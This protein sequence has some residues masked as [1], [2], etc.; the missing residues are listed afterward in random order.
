MSS[1]ETACLFHEP[2][3]DFPAIHP[4]IEQQCAG[5]NRQLATWCSLRVKDRPPTDQFPKLLLPPLG[6]A[7]AAVLTLQNGLGNE[8]ALARLFPIEQIMGGLCF[9]CLNRTAPRSY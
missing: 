3:G 6:W 9:V 2:E 7:H 1:G 4:Q 5:G 8:E